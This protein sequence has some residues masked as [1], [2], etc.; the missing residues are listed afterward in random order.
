MNT[1]ELSVLIVGAKATLRDA[2]LS[3]EKSSLRLVFVCDERNRMLAMATEGD[4]RRALLEGHGLLTTL[5]PLSNQSPKTG[6]ASLSREELVQMLSKEVH[7]LP[8][9][10]DE[11]VLKDILFQ[12]SKTFI[13]VATPVVGELEYRYVSD[14]VISGWISSQGRYIDRLEKDFAAFCGTNYAVVTSNGT[15]AIHLALVAAGIGPGDEVI[16]PAFTFA[17]TANA[18]L[19][20]GAKPV[21]VDVEKVSWCIDP[22]AIE[23]AITPKTRAIIPVHIYGN[24]CDMGIIMDVAKTHNLIV[25][26][27]AAEAHGAEYAG[28]RVGSI[29]H[30]GTFSFYGNK[31]ITTGEGGAVVCNDAETNEQLRKLRD[32]GMSKEVRYWHDVVGYNYRMTNMQ[33]AL[34]VAQLERWDQMKVARSNIKSFYDKS[35]S[36]P[37]LTKARPLRQAEDICWIYS[38]TVSDRPDLNRDQLLSTLKKSNVDSRPLFYPLPAMPPYHVPGWEEK[39]PVSR[40]ISMNGFSIPSSL[41]MTTEQLRYVASVV[42]EVFS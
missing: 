14:A 30:M 36:F 20:C 31:I 27:D 8:I 15:V 16:V 19:Y 21:F 12:D 29:G 34:G 22:R 18:V 40:S 9:V 11:G 4:V 41:E 6:L 26:E 32:H 42:N 33:A 28:E 2:L 23:A 5:L 13:P 25:I 1:E 38:M 10:D 7:C 39:Y 24:P 3:F 35:I 37:G 17:A